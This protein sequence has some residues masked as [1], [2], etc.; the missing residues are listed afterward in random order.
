MGACADAP[1]V[2]LLLLLL[3]LLTRTDEKYAHL[4]DKDIWD[5]AW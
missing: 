5:E 4:T 2:V 1:A 3:L